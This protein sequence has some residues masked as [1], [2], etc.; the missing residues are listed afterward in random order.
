[1]IDLPTCLTLLTPSTQREPF[2]LVDAMRAIDEVNARRARSATSRSYAQTS[3]DLY[4]GRGR[5]PEPI[6]LPEIVV[7]SCAG[8]RSA[9][10]V[11]GSE[12]EFTP[13]HASWSPVSPASVASEPDSPLIV[14]PQ[15]ASVPRAYLPSQDKQ[16]CDEWTRPRNFEHEVVDL[17]RQSRSPR[18]TASSHRESLKTGL[19]FVVRSHSA[20]GTSK[21]PFDDADNCVP[22]TSSVVDLVEVLQSLSSEDDL[23]GAALASQYSKRF[24]PI[25]DAF[26]SPATVNPRNVF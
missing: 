6:E 22:T 26:D 9:P 11:D 1:M 10:I 21:D 25:V 15:L 7:Y 23:T 3:F 5:T 13:T 8:T 20:G 19:G 16:S 18:S 12:F 2:T 14:T 4:D 17:E 24:S